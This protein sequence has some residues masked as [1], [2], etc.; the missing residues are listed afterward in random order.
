MFFGF[1]FIVSGRKPPRSTLEK[2]F[3]QEAL[4]SGQARYDAQAGSVCAF[5]DTLN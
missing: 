3:L 1:P 4:A 5:R 2:I